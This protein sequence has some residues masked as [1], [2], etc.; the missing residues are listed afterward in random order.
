MKQHD[1]L[2]VRQLVPYR[3][4][5]NKRAR[6]LQA[7]PELDH[8]VCQCPE[9]RE[10]N[11]VHL[12]CCLDALLVAQ[13]VPLLF[14]SLHPLR[15]LPRTVARRPFGL[16]KIRHDT[17]VRQ[18]LGDLLAQG[19]FPA[20]TEKSRRDNVARE[21]LAA[22]DI[23]ALFGILLARTKSR[24]GSTGGDLLACLERTRAR[25]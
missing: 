15:S 18:G 1:P 7:T 23:C 22:I 11:G 19:L 20:S 5:A 4:A 21:H 13:V 25:F 16:F 6:A 9:L 12:R 17:A 3:H 8:G 14:A 24:H 10:H 2:R